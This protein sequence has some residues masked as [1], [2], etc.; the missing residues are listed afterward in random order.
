M[1]HAENHTWRQ[2]VAIRR[3]PM[4]ENNAFDVQQQKLSSLA[5]TSTSTSTSTRAHEKFNLIFRAEAAIVIQV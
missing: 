3:W 5:K 2:T 4:E 1:R